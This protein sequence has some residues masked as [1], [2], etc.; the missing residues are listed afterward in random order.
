MIW[1]GEPR[2]CA[3]RPASARLRRQTRSESDWL[4]GQ[5]KEISGVPC[6][7]SWPGRQVCVWPRGRGRGLR[8]YVE[9]ERAPYGTR[10]HEPGIYS[11]S[12]VEV[13]SSNLK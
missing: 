10:T 5:R 11:F 8:S 9:D 12:G 7:G 3:A 2:A 13:V 6:V 4:R 1:L